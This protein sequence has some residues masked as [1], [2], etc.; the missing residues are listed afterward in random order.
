M[1][2]TIQKTL[3]KSPAEALFGRK[4]CRERWISNEPIKEEIP[5][6]KY[7][8]KRRFQIGEEVLVKIETRTKDKDRF[9]GPYEIVQQIHD[10]R[11][12]LKHTN[13]RI[14]E[15]NVEKIKKFLKGGCKE[16]LKN[17]FI[18]NFNIYFN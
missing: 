9:E 1:N 14:I 10:R 12:R 5:K 2:A 7:L 4:I 13:G 3:G 18:F 11:Y 16:L 8:T 15:R 6:Q 17:L